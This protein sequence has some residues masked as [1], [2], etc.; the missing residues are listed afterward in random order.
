M[1]HQP[2]LYARES[3]VSATSTC[4][5][6]SLLGWGGGAGIRTRNN[7]H[8]GGRTKPLPLEGHPHCGCVPGCV[9]LMDREKR[10]PD[11]RRVEAI[12]FVVL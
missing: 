8:S 2:V 10:E 3:A 7:A 9:Q 5:T 12:D 1:R 11:C 6:R 4:M